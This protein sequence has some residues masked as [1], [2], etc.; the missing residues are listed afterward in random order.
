VTIFDADTLLVN[1]MVQRVQSAFRYIPTNIN[2]NIVSNSMCKELEN[3]AKLLVTLDSA[4][5]HILDHDKDNFKFWFIFSE[6]N[7]R[8]TML[9]E[10]CKVNPYRQGV[11]CCA[12]FR[13][14]R[15]VQDVL[16]RAQN[17]A[18]Q[19][20]SRILNSEDDLS[21]TNDIISQYN[22]GSIQYIIC[23]DTSPMHLLSA[24]DAKNF[25]IVINF[26]LRSS[27]AFLKRC[28]VSHYLGNGKKI[29]CIS[30]IDND[31]TRVYEDVEKNCG[32]VLVD[33]P[34]NVQAVLV[35][36]DGKDTK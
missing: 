18:D 31:Q 21:P 34:S 32:V 20:H 33:L 26:Q 23:H 36:G 25:R 28:S 29:H 12:D 15:M 1:P 13:Q 27:S 30:L 7:L 2:V 17:G 6:A 14:C 8:Q 19:Y 35:D 16:M 5:K 9:L 10:L 4:K 24:V 3:N 22:N 11:I